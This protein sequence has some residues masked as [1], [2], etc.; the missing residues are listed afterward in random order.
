MMPYRKKLLKLLEERKILGVVILDPSGNH[1]WHT[2]VFPQAKGQFIDGYYVIHAWVT[3]PASLFIAGVK[4]LTILN[5]YPDYWLLT[6]TKGHGS[7]ILQKSPN[8]YFFLCY[9]DETMEP[10]DI[11][12]EIK[13]VAELFIQGSQE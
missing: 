8:K 11:Q 9:L 2:G 4:Y 5:A 13:A 1:W 12:K 6:D 3:Y 10:A 7:L